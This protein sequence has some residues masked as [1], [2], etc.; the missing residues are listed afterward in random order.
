[1]LPQNLLGCSCM[2]MAC[3]AF[4]GQL[5]Q[6]L[7]QLADVLLLAVQRCLSDD[8]LVLSIIRPCSFGA[9]PVLRHQHV[10]QSALFRIQLAQEL[11]FQL[12]VSLLCVLSEVW[13]LKRPKEDVEEWIKRK[14]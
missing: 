4:W 3:L 2:G 8:R 13:Q 5:L 1:M 10:L 11:L 12:R 14:L 6:L 7:L 9:V